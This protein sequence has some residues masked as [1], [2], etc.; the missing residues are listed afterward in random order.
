MDEAPDEM[1]AA[2]PAA[3]APPVRRNLALNML[4]AVAGTGF[5]HVCQFAVVVLLNR[6]SS[7]DVTG[8]YFL[9]LAVATPVLLC[10]G[11]ELRGALVADVRNEFTVGTYQALRGVMILP[12]SV[13]LATVAF[14]SWFQGVA[15]GLVL[16]LVC[17]FALRLVWALAEVG[18]GTFQRRERLDL[19]CWAYA[20]RGVALLLPAAIL[21]PLYAKLRR[22]PAIAPMIGALVFGLQA[23]A[24]W[25]IYLGFERRRVL[26]PAIWNVSWSWPAIGRLAWQ[27]LPL[28]LV[29]LLINLC[30][31]LPRWLFEWGPNVADGRAQLG[32]FGSLAYV[33]MIGNLVTI[34][35][36]AA[37]AN[38]LSWYYL[39]DPQRF[40]RLGVKLIGLALVVGAGVLLLAAFA[41]KWFL[42]ALFTARYAPFV[43][44]FQ[45]L[46][47]AHG[48]ALLTNVFGAAVTQ[49][50]FFWLQVPLQAVVLTVTVVAAIILIPGPSPVYGAAWTMLVR[51]AVQFVL[52]AAAVTV[53]FVYREQL[54]AWLEGRKKKT[55]AGGQG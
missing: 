22:D 25:L 42:T 28:G 48:L 2:P 37:A 38:R 30:D 6:C 29:A 19:M 20:L 9:G 23:T 47:V 8:Q 11:L 13:V 45:I 5:F 40:L 44:E 34:Q 43:V 4:Y 35:A 52:Y 36:S 17:M 1:L 26:D 41:G 54:A 12:A 32:Y 16:V 14:L 7:P 51:A 55:P 15:P 39:H 3:P 18:W 50:R 53:G 10:F 24:F 46:A 49:M 27:T 31:S 21:L 33:T